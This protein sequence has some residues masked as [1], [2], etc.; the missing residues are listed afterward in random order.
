MYD[1]IIVGAGPAGLTSGIYARR[2]NKKVLILEANSYGGAIINTHAIDNFPT[3]PHI[4]GFDFATK[5]YEQTKE[6]G[7]EVKFEKVVEIED[8]KY[9]KVVTNKGTYETKAII[10]A[11]GSDNRKLGLDKEK[12]FTGKGVS[13]CATC[14]G[15]F[16]RGKDIAVIGGG[17]T[18]LDDAIYL[19]DIVNKV[20]L[21]NR[22]DTFK[23]DNGFV[24]NLKD[25]V[26][27]IYNANITELLGEDKLTG[28]KLNNERTINIDGLFIA[29]GRVPENEKFASLIN[30]DEKG[31]I[32]ASEDCH[33]NIEG[34]YVAGDNR[35]KE[36]RQLTT[37]VSDGTVA[38]IEAIKYIN[39]LK[40][41]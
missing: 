18:A 38:A 26:E 29:V 9:K 2:A 34:I 22:K 25:N 27:V 17:S 31:Y 19:Q 16:Y 12:E 3:Q 15:A 39:N 13:Y 23:D 20:Y 30:V 4:N 24:N 11:T 40:E 35:T 32:I 5:L 21:I 1:V 6:L 28:I 14:D 8:G 41:E 36:I 7:A 10:L 33:T 37:A